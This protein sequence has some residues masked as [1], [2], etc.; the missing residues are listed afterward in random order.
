[1]IFEVLPNPN[2]SMICMLNRNM[3]DYK[4]TFINIEI[5]HKDKYCLLKN[6]ERQ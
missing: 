3:Q 2:S 5:G 1:M 4:E 6:R